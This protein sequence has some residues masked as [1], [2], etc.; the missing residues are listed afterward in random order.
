MTT[1]DVI[2]VL[3]CL[4]G[5][6]IRLWVDGGWG[7]DALVGEQTRDHSDLDLAVDRNDLDAAWQALAELGFQHDEAGEPGLPARLLLRDERGR[8]LDL[9]PLVFD[10]RGD[11]WQQLSA[12]GR[13]WGRYPASELDAMGVIGGQDV[14]CL[15]P[16]LQA[17]FRMGYELSDR[18]EHDLR[19]LAERFG[20]ARPP[21]LQRR[22]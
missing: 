19:L 16:R 14:R 17:R 10:E 13:A 22:Q 8:K 11:G 7:V 2:D 6:G 18:D 5:A 20:V 12:T 21:G 9:H 3:D 4:R 15:S 1:P